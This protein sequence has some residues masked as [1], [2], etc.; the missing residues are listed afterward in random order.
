MDTIQ[1]DVSDPALVTAIRANLSAFF[2]HLARSFPNGYFESERF[3]R[4]HTPIRQAWFN[5]VL[6][7]HAPREQDET[8]IKE[9]IQY[10]RAQKVGT[11]SWWMEPGL[12]C[13]EW[14]TVL[15]RHGFGF[16][17]DTPGMALD[18]QTLDEPA[19]P[20]DGLEIR[21]V[22]GEEALR[23][24][25]R[26]FTAGYGLPAEW[27]PS[28]YDLTSRLG[29][30]LP[31]R[32]YI[33][34]LNARPVATSC[35]FLGG[36]AAGIYSVATLPEARGRGIGAALTL[37]PLQEAREMGYRIGVLQS[38]EMGYNIYKRLG[39]RHLCQIENFYLALR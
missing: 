13:A 31:I 4:W 2:H 26:V 28:I 6:S 30:H 10:F 9:T 3:T 35:L 8:F 16:S 23:S 7:A 27:E 36:G 19:R 1:T 17:E 39:F 15:L 32:N 33:G 38:S 21:V 34:Y 20:A 24:W 37:R 29:L 14:E 11:F 22:T 18:L 25:A 12:G 5:G